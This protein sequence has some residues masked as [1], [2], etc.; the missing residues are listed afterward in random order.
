MMCF[1]AAQPANFPAQT[2]QK[3]LLRIGL[4]DFVSRTPTCERGARRAIGR[5]HLQSEV[6][7]I[8]MSL[9]LWLS[10]DLDFE[11]ASQEVQ[12]EVAMRGV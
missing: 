1:G 8:A 11:A 7:P 4:P 3:K 6:R 2:N 10:A 12:I 5:P 9:A